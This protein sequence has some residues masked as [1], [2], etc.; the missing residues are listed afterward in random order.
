[1]ILIQPINHFLA[2]LSLG[3]GFLIF[4][5]IPFKKKIA[6]LLIFLLVGLGIGMHEH[7]AQDE[8]AYSREGFLDNVVFVKEHPK[9]PFKEAICLIIFNNEERCNKYKGDEK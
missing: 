1:V 9:T 4:Y 6:L 7:L 5:F 2:G 8:V 3:I